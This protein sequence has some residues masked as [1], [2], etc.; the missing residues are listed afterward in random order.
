[1]KIKEITSK[2]IYRVIGYCSVGMG[3][4][5]L[6]YFNQIVVGCIIITIGYLLLS[7]YE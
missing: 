7:K 1:M 3:T 4:I 6:I 2:N 5:Q